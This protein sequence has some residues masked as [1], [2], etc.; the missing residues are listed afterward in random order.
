MLVL[1]QI[2]PDG[3]APP[4]GCGFSVL[5]GLLGTFIDAAQT[6][7]ALCRPDGFTVSEGND[8]GRTV[9][10]AQAAAVAAILGKE[11]LGASGKFI[12]PKA[13]KMGLHPSQSTFM[14]TVHRLLLLD[15]LRHPFQLRTGNGDL[16][17]DFSLVV[18]IG[19]NDV[20]V[21][22]HQTVTA[23]EG[24]YLGK[25]LHGKAG[26]ST[27]GADTE[28]E[29]LGLGQLFH[30]FRHDLRCAPGV[31]RKDKA[32]LLGATQ[33]RQLVQVGDIIGLIPGQSRQL[34]G[35]PRRV[36]CSGKIENHRLCSLPW[37]IM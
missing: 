17:A 9:F 21:G 7:E 1:R 5:D 33:I 26:I 32:D 25:L 6:L 4:P 3:V 19:A 15:L 36:A 22:H 20:V 27:A 23:V 24:V 14:D 10:H 2:L 11:G 30:K 34:P 12:E 35:C 37:F 29:R 8:M 31:D 16:L 13:H 28:G 18:G